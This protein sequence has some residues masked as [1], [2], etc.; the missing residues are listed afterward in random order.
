[1]TA[2]SMQVR[3]WRVGSPN[4]KEVQP[5]QC[6]K[7]Q[8][9]LLEGR[10]VVEV[11]EGVVGVRGFIPLEKILTF[12]SIECLKEYFTGERSYERLPRRVP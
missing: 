8:C 3:R 7:C 5:L 4:S 9:E 2:K 11:Q 1:M 6:L 12:C 10:D